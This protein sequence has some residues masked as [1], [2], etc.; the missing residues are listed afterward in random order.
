M[1]WKMAKGIGE[2]KHKVTLGDKGLESWLA[3]SVR[4]CV[5]VKYARW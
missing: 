3:M 2:R 5:V 4:T 1:T